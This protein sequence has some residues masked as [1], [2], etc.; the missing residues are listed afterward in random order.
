VQCLE[1]E[2]VLGV[3]RSFAI[4]YQPSAIS[5]GQHPLLTFI[6]T[7]GIHFIPPDS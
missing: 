5:L 6:K 3:S 2:Y 1:T 4:S 7:T